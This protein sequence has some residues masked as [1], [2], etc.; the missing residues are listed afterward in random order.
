MEEACNLWDH[1]IA[2]ST[3]APGPMFH[4]EAV[5]LEGQELAGHP[6]V[7]VLLQAHTPNS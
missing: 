6:R 7:A 4:P 3:Q 5:W 1:G 2:V